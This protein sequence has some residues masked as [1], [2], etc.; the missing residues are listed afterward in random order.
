MN[1]D[2]LVC[3]SIPY[4]KGWRA[5]ID[6]EK[7]E[8]LNCDIQ[9]MALEV[10]AGEHDI[11][12]RYTTPLLKVGA[13]MTLSGFVVLGYLLIRDKRRSKTNKL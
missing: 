11:E 7:V 1:K 13:L 4:S 3:L 2:G 9:Y 5:Y 6:G 8:L 12:L 10:K